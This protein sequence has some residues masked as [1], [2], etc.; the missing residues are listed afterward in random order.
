MPLSRPALGSSRDRVVRVRYRN[1]ALELWYA[2][3]YS[4]IRL[5]LARVVREGV[6]VVLRDHPEVLSMPRSFTGEVGSQ[7]LHP[8]AGSK[9]LAAFP[10]LLSWLRDAAYS[11]GKPVGMVQLAVRPKGAVYVVTLR[12]QDQGGMMIQVEDANLDDAFL[13]LDAALVASPPPWTRDPYPLG[14][15]SS[16]KK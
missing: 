12:V 15:I 13:L 11:D 9:V 6:D 2:S 16:K 3:R 14:Q 4:P 10:E 8:R 5:R 7:V 1:L